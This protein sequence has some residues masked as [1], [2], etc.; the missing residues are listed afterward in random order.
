[1]ND[2]DPE[3]WF[4]K[5]LPISEGNEVVALVDGAVYMRHLHDQILGMVEGDSLFFTVWRG[6]PNQKLR[7]D[8]KS[9]P[10]TALLPVMLDLD[11]RRAVVRT[12]AWRPPLTSVSFLSRVPTSWLAFLNQQWENK[13]LVAEQINLLPLNTRR[14]SFWIPDEIRDRRARRE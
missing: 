2:T 3:Y 13:T 7:P 10:D 11:R 8:Q 1:V 6:T 14:R 4:L 9:P 5:K 12:L